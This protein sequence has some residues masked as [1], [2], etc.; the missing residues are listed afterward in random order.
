ME[1]GDC[2][3]PRPATASLFYTAMIPSRWEGSARKLTQRAPPPPLLGLPASPQQAAG[4]RL[5]L[6][7]HHSFFVFL[8][9]GLQMDGP[10]CLGPRWGQP[11]LLFLVSGY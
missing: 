9:G 7:A 1:T 10:A 6:A 5:S 2:S 4:I 8:R 11:S 3:T